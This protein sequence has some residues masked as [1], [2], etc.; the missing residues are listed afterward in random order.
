MKYKTYKKNI[1]I[2]FL[3]NT[4]AGRFLLRPLCSRGFS[5]ICGKFLDTSLSRHLIPVFIKSQKIS[6]EECEK[7]DFQSFNDFFTRKLKS[8][9]RPLPQDPK[10]LFAPCDGF[11]SAYRIT[12]R[13]V[14]PVKQSL[15]SISDLLNEDPLHRRFKDGICLV[16][17]LC[18]NHYH[19]YLYIDGGVKGDNVFIPG[20]LHTVRP[21]AL[22]R[23]SV[24][25]Q[26]CREYTV[27]ETDSFGTAVQVEVGAMLVGK[28]CNHHNAGVIRRGAEKGM[29]LYGGSTVILL[30]QKDSVSV[31]EH[32]FTATESGLELP[33]KMGQA[34]GKSLHP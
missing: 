29:F 11:L 15:Y 4:A 13:L 26:N 23:Y 21:I 16:F 3:Y 27:M 12:N 31:D 14:I 19:R 17:R 24:F 8:E 2:K 1:L 25:I 9:T 28:I 30:L 32:F 33:V 20:T 22:D 10:A 6:L 7:T 18:V 34:I 5:N